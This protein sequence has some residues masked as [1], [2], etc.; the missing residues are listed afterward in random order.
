[1]KDINKLPFN[2]YLKNK[3]NGNYVVTILI[4]KKYFSDWKKF[5]SKLWIQYCIN[6]NLGLIIFNDYLIK[7]TNKDWMSPNWQRLVIASYVEKNIKEI[8]NICF[9][10]SDIL[11]NPFSPNI[12]DDFDKNKISL[13]SLVNN[14]PYSISEESLR[15]RMAL[16]RKFFL[17]KDYPLNSSLNVLH[18]D[19]WKFY[20]IKK[21]ENYFCSGVMVYNVK[22]F[23]KLFLL[24]YLKYSKKEKFKILGCEPYIISEILNST[25]KINWINYKYQTHWSYEINYKYP[26]LYKRINDFPLVKDCIEATLMNCYFLHFSGSLVDMEMWKN[27]NIFQRKKFIFFYKKY[28]LYRK[29]KLKNK[30]L[31]SKFQ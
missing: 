13:V 23:F 7:K 4:G 12:F 17:R 20:K 6:N 24:I 2:F 19:M 18:K 27:K 10:D 14:L 31:K 9:L 25:K 1:M 5:S 8:K 15:R 22:N 28:L 11:I 16:N 29:K 30:I 3:I 26:F 21:I